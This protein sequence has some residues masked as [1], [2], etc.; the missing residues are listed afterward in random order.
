MQ[1][2]SRIVLAL[3]FLTIVTACEKVIDLDLNS[4][5][6]KF[7]IEGHV[8]NGPGPYLVKVTK[9]RN[10]SD[11]NNFEGITNAFIMISDNQGNRDTLVQTQP[12]RYYTTTLA[13]VPGRTYFLEVRIENETYAA[14]STMPIQVPL[15][16]V[17]V[18]DF[19]AL[20]NTLKVT[21]AYFRDPAGVKNYYR[22]VLYHNQKLIK[23]IYILNDELN[24]GLPVD[25]V[26]PIMSFDE[27][28]VS[29]DSVQ[30]DMWCIDAAVYNYFFTL[31]QTINQSSSAPTNPMTNLSGD[32]LGYFSAH[33]LQTEKLKAP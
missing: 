33:T 2:I 25:R 16:S 17:R 18:N 1:T 15:D 11:D 31:D 22:H 32:A 9:T 19:V 8:T 23:S 14:Q 13:G 5:S 21:H 4:A 12:G 27:E 10:F 3:V 26:L 20:G 30:V 6:P 7:V 29:G 24:D 28:L